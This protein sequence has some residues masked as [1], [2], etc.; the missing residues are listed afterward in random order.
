MREDAGA[1]DHGGSAVHGHGLAAEQRGADVA[2]DQPGDACVNDCAGD[3][4]GGRETAGAERLR[5]LAV[6]LADR[7]S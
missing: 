1:G 5:A 4:L 7:K 2:D 3:G 6:F